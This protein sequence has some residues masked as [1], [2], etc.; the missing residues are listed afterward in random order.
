MRAWHIGRWA[1]VV[2]LALPAVAACARPPARGP[3]FT[4][5]GA[6]ASPVPPPT[7]PPGDG[8]PNHADNNRWKRR[9]ELTVAEKQAGDQLAARIRPRLEA[10]RKAGDFTTASAQRALLD[11][12]V[13]AATITVTGMRTPSWETSAPVGVVYA[14]TFPAAGCVIG[15]VRPERLLVEVT[16]AAAEFG[17]LEPFS[18]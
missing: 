12:G 15:D 8:P 3:V 16:G 18:H 2:A 7:G 14:V 5:P 9:H 4:P 1:A 10:L 13:P 6:S 11:A 17:C